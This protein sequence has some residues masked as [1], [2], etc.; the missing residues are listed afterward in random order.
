[1]TYHGQFRGQPHDQGP[2][3]HHHPSVDLPTWPSTGPHRGPA[4]AGPGHPGH[5]YPGPAYP[6]P[7]GA[8][9][10]A[11]PPYGY[12]PPP[13]PPWIAHRY[14]GATVA[15]GGSAVSVL[16][17]LFLP[18]QVIFETLTA[19]EVIEYNAADDPAWNLV[20]VTPVIAALAGVIALLQRG[21]PNRR[22]SS[23]IRAFDWVR[24]LA[25]LVIGIY[26]LNIVVL[27]AGSAGSDYQDF[28]LSV[29]NFL[30]IGFWFG[31]FGMIAAHIGA[32]IE[33]RNLR[34]WKRESEAWA[35][36]S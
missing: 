8:N 12:G 33:L 24:N 35:G 5:F 17:F 27:S 29:T 30:G 14:I 11:P 16:A 3:G 20:W 13:A 6:G 32:T 7:G 28:D 4:A 22:P 15:A 1:M 31:L 26:L 18:Y 9:E 2:S 10:G 34:R 36:W 25:A 21:G 19:P 23:R